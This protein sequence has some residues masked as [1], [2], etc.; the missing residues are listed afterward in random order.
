MLKVLAIISSILYPVLIFTSLTYFDASPRVLAL[1]LLCVAMIYFISNTNNINKK[2]FKRFQL[3]ATI[4]IASTLALL[5]FITENS[6][7]IKFYPVFISLFLLLSFSITLKSPPTIIFRFATL[8]DKT[9]RGGVNEKKVES[10]CRVVTKVW[11]C[12]FVFNGLI[13]LATAIFA[14]YKIWTL[15]NGL[16]SYIFIGLIA[17]VEFIVRKVK[18]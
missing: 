8:A 12:F 7:Y 2:G 6:G 17:S 18:M 13:A 14:N 5:T 1:V 9:I 11:V 16:I 15:Y 10:Y 4:I 3:W